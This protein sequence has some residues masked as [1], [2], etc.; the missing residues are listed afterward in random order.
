MEDF[1]DLL[2]A[3]GIMVLDDYNVFY[4]VNEAIQKFESLHDINGIIDGS[5]WYFVK[6]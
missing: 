5:K 4:G 3:N 2:E 6:H 1:W